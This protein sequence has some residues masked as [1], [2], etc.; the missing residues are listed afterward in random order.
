MPPLFGTDPR[1]WSE[2]EVSYWLDWCQTEFGLKSLN[3]EL[4]SMPGSKLCALDRET[5]LELIT[6]CTAGEILWEHLETIRKGKD[7]LQAIPG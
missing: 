4:R 5:F 6:D 2:W 7:K 1:L 3:P